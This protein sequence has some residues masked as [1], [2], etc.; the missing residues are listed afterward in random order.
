MKAFQLDKKLLDLIINKILQ[1]IDVRQIILYGSRARGDAKPNSDIDLAIEADER[2]G[3][4]RTILDEEI[5]TLLKF[6][7]VNLNNAGGNL[8]EEIINEGIVIYE[9]NK[10]I[11]E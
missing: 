8:K 3:Y 4:I 10:T 5:P 11:A 2:I 9:K 7:V 6:D 1:N